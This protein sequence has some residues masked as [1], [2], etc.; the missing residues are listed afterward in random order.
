M[1]VSKDVGEGGMKL[2]NIE[3]VAKI[4]GISRSTTM[5]MIVDGSLPAVCLRAGR[6]KSVWRVREENLQ[7]WILSK[8]RQVAKAFIGKNGR[9]EEDVSQ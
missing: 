4:L 7:R 8:E 9:V 6:R 1:E 3:E 5:R 2:L